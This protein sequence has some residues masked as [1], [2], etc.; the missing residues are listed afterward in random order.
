MERAPL[1]LAHE[2]SRPHREPGS[3][4]SSCLFPPSELDYYD[5]PSVNA[6]CQ[7]ICDQWDN[8]GALTQKRRE[9]LEVRAARETGACLCSS[10]CSFLLCDS[11]CF[12]Q[13]CPT[14]PPQTSP[15]HG[16]SAEGSRGRCIWALLCGDASFPAL[17]QIS[18]PWCGAQR[19]PVP[20]A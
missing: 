17:N 9:A 4:D 3:P 6:R 13:E 8:L 15:S 7:K 20:S 14:G 19:Y 1:A 12:G 10:A 5:S 16:L 11:L 2:E 18:S